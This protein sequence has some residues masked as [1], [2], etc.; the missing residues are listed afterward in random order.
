MNTNLSLLPYTIRT[1]IQ[2]AGGL[3]LQG[4]FAFIGAHSFMYSCREHDQECRSRFMSKRITSTATGEAVIVDVHLSFLVNGRRGFKWVMQIAYEPDDTY[5][6]WLSQSR[7][8]RI[9]I[10]D[11]RRD[12]YCDML[13]E[14]IERVYDEAI[15]K[16][17]NGFIPID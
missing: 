16:H 7:G 1:I 6:V 2:Q 13:Q 8:R 3:G 12:V 14:V 11:E 15:E 9:T 10:L 5:T 17:C 4:A